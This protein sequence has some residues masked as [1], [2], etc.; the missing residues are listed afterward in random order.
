M[1]PAAPVVHAPAEVAVPS[2]GS[3]ASQLLLLAVAAVC[4]VA[5]A[6]RRR[7]ER[8]PHHSAPP[9]AEAESDSP[10]ADVIPMHRAS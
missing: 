2:S 7:A 8:L 3:G 5:L 6:M 10:E 1:R 9:S 4:L